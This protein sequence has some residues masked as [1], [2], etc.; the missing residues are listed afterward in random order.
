LLRGMAR[1]GPHLDRT[2][3]NFVRAV[4]ARPLH[5]SHAGGGG[6]PETAVRK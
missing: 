2:R 1:R 3:P 6:Q 4:C 5:L